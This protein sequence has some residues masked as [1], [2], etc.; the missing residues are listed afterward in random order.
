MK[1]ALTMKDPKRDARA[2]FG[3]LEQGVTDDLRS[4]YNRL[5]S[6]AELCEFVN[7]DE[8]ILDRLVVGVW[9]EEFRK[10]VMSDPN[11]TLKKAMEMAD[12]LMSVRA[13]SKGIKERRGYPQHP[14][15][16]AVHYM[17]K[18]DQQPDR[19]SEQPNY[20]PGRNDRPG[21]RPD[22]R[23]RPRRQ[24]YDNRRDDRSRRFDHGS[25]PD[26]YGNQGEE[27]DCAYCMRRHKPRECPSWGKECR[28]CGNVGH[29][30]G[31]I[32]CPDSRDTSRAG[33]RTGQHAQNVTQNCYGPGGQPSQA[34]PQQDQ[35]TRYSNQSVRY[36]GHQASAYPEP[37]QTERSQNRSQ[38]ARSSPIRSPPYADSAVLHVTRDSGSLF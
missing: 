2:R 22:D 14:Q 31:S 24:D 32:K 8:A 6:V 29:F 27:K 19:R 4:F 38:E 33:P 25:R 11:I 3:T 35:P 15:R 9:D 18:R 30:E 7:R 26:R 20:R 34:R 23:N 10:K 21:S 37:H 16:G 28:K 5:S 17:N 36:M 1:N 12:T 13:T